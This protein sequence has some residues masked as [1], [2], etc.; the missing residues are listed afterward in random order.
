MRAVTRGARVHR[1][2]RSATTRSR[3]ICGRCSR[4]CIRSR[5]KTIRSTS[6]AFGS[7]NRCRHRVATPHDH[8]DP[9]RSATGPARSR[10]AVARMDRR[11]DERSD[12]A[13]P[14]HLGKRQRRVDDFFNVEGEPSDELEIRGD[15]AGSSGSAA[16]MTRGRITIHGNA[17]MHLGAYMKGARSRSPE[18]RPTGSAAR[19]PADSSGSAETPAGRSARPTAAAARG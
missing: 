4:R 11:A 13:L 18:T 16:A 6:S 19:C 7:P 8:A 17:G 15:A 9:Q 5:S 10:N 14:V 2:A 12:P 1:P 3:N